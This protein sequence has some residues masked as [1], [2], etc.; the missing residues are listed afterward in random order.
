MPNVFVIRQ[1]ELRDTAS[2]LLSSTAL[3][4]AARL[5]LWARGEPFDFAAIFSA[6]EARH[7]Y[8]ST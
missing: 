6:G 5:G 1:M 2:F 4:T 8:H 7:R 3:D